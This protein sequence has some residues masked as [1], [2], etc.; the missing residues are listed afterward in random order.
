[1][2]E[3]IGDVSSVNT[4]PTVSGWT[5]L[6]LV[7]YTVPQEAPPQ[8]KKVGGW[9]DDTTTKNKKKKELPAEEEE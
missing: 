2:A 5:P 6:I 1:M 3:D 7:P 4:Q 8:R 9:A